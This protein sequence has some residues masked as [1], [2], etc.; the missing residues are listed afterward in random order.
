VEKRLRGKHVR[1]SGGK[2]GM[3][4]T[5]PEKRFPIKGKVDQP[6]DE[7][8][9]ERLRKKK[10]KKKQ[11]NKKKKK[12]KKKPNQ[13][14]ESCKII[15]SLLGTYWESC[16]GAAELRGKEKRRQK[17]FKNPFKVGSEHSTS[18]HSIGEPQRSKGDH[19][20][21]MGKQSAKRE[22]SSLG[23]SARRVGAPSLMS[24]KAITRKKASKK[25]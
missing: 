16:F 10:K 8:I 6:R 11:K 24:R 15:A 1:G 19:S 9:R 5:L 21:G 20:D 23:S 22:I 3:V 2:S 13:R 14:P 4:Y 12:K 17:K 7:R 25:D 18:R